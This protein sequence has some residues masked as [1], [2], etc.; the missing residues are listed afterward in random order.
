[1]IQSKSGTGKTLVFCTIILERYNPNI[2]A[3]QSLIVV[4]TREIALQVESYLN[5]IG[6][7]C[8]GNKN[9]W[10]FFF[11]W[12]HCQDMFRKS[13]STDLCLCFFVFCFLFAGFSV[14]CVIGGRKIAE[15]RKRISK[16]KAIVGTPGRL[17]HL[18]RNQFV[19][20]RNIEM[21]V[22]DEADKLMTD[23]FY[24][25][26]NILIDA[27]NENRQII[28]S[29]ATYENG[30]DKLIVS[31]MHNPIGISTSRDTSV[32]IGV[33]Q[34]IL[35]AESFAIPKSVENSTASIQS[36]WR[37]VSAVEYILCT[38][39]FKQ[40]ILFSNSQFRANSFANYLTQ[41]KWTVELILGS[42][43][44]NTRTEILQRFR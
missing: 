41:N 40:C 38:T 3:P 28:A 10:N 11:F 18:I 30:L 21:L 15:D 19:S 35:S 31:F 9:K 7:C 13:I 14:A 27:L 1:M 22:L 43:D 42:H 26:I 8:S 5:S 17:L 2:K 44:Q 36:M 23:D 20:L 16:C 4:P 32:L 24:N 34:F 29:S 12:L 33:K 37:K 39:A 6:T 25:G